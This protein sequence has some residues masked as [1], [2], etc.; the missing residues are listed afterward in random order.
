MK[1]KV[2]AL[3][4]I[5]GEDGN[6]YT[7]EVNDIV[8]LEDRNPQNLTGCEVDFEVS[9]KAAKNIFII[10]ASI[11]IANIKGQLMS[12]DTQSIRFKF[13]L[14]MGL[15][16]GAGFISLIP[17]LGWVLGPILL[18]SGFVVYVLAVFGAR[19][20]SESKTLLKNFILSMVIFAVAFILAMIFGGSALVGFISGY[21]S[22]GGFGFTMAM[23]LLII[24]GIATFVYQLLF[25]RE[26]AFINEQKF[27]LWGFYVNVLGSLTTLI[28]IGWLLM[29]AAF[30]LWV[31]GFYQM[32]NIRKRTDADIMPWF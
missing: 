32:K 13:L 22:A 28:M 9:E 8:N 3:G 5:S 24:G 14:A 4:L 6:R 15:Y 20:A 16:F 21:D 17:F 11:N 1:G 12:N 31:I 2:L 25:F 27:L 19:H 10:G 29:F 7:F 18:I 26:L 30:V 23:I